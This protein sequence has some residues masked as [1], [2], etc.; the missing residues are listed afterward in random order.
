MLDIYEDRV[1]NRI[2]KQA[3]ECAILLFSMMLL[4]KPTLVLL[5]EKSDIL[6]N[7]PN[8]DEAQPDMT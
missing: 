3:N 4:L 5:I 6:Y 7:I 8:K 2:Y 1:H